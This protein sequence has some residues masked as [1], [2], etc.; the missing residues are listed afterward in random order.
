MR[1]R[2]GMTNKNFSKLRRDTILTAAGRDPTANHGIVNPPVYHA[3]TV[4]FPTLA[5][6]E[7]AEKG[8]FKGPVYGRHGTPTTFALQDAVAAL[9]G[10]DE[11]AILPSGMAAIAVALLAFL[12]TGDH[13]LVT[14][15]AYAPARRF[16]AQ[17]LKPMG[18]EATFFDPAIGAGIAELIQP[19]TK[20]ILCESP[21]SLTFEVQDVPAIVAAAHAKGVKVA[22]DNT[23]ATPLYFPAIKHGVDVSISAGTKYLVGHSDAM[24]GTL[25][26]H[27][28]DA[29]RIRSKIA[30]L[31][32]STAPDDCYLALRGLRTLA[33][34]LPRHGETGLKLARFLQTRRE[35]ARVYHPALPGSPGH[36]LWKRD[37][38]GAT[39]LFSFALKPV[40]R[41]ALARMVDDLTL[42]GMGYSWGGYESLLLP[43]NPKSIRTTVPWT[44]PGPLL[45]VHAGLE[46]PDD[47]IEDLAA[48]LDRLS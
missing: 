47:L 13:L 41:D 14:D 17:M 18:I 22:F 26:F 48:G 4:L 40:S 25:A 44:E 10:S 28:G 6:L 7:L 20:I 23:W 1:Q 5:D 12:K 42:Y 33:V 29:K 30:D 19:N 9:E 11:A 45:R 3:S 21:G 34:R 15:N 36:E 24:I 35:V 31:G 8:Q 43:V 27:S 46:D 38:S 2:D 39:G 32:Y 16:C 37:F